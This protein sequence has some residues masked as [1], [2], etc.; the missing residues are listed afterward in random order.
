MSCFRYRVQYSY[1]P[2]QWVKMAIPINLDKFSRRV[3]SKSHVL[4]PSCSEE[5]ACY[6][7][8]QAA[9]YKLWGFQVVQ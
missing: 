8:I 3:P 4:D 2:R 7:L 9:N 1:H 6:K 5:I